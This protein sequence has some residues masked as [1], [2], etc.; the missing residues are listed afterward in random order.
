MKSA[1]TRYRVMAWITGVLLL[2]LVFV[3]MPMKYLGDNDTPVAVIGVAHGWMFMLYLLT[4]L[5]LWVRCQWKVVKAF[6]IAIA[7]T[8]P[9]MSFVAEHFVRLDVER[10]IGSAIEEPSAA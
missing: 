10:L 2:L 7:G 3:A 9:F 1:L 6:L 5:D 8:V 4:V